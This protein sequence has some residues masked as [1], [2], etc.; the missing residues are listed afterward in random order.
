MNLKQTRFEG[1]LTNEQLDIVWKQWIFMT[2]KKKGVCMWGKEKCLDMKH[3]MLAAWK[4]E[5]TGAA[6]EIKH[7]TFI[8]LISFC[9]QYKKLPFHCAFPWKSKGLSCNV[10]WNYY[11]ILNWQTVFRST[12]SFS[13]GYYFPLAWISNRGAI[14][15]DRAVSCGVIF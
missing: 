1:R 3:R 14:P 15:F 4:I 6:W 12:F 7:W 5:I 8:Y 9:I 13:T 10:V 11:K 2:I